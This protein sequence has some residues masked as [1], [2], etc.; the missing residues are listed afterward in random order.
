MNEK[1]RSQ[2]VVEMINNVEKIVRDYELAIKKN[3]FDIKCPYPK[4]IKAYENIRQTLINFGW[5]EQAMIFNE[6]VK[7]YQEKLE[8]DKKLRIIEAQKVQKQ[9]EIEDFYKKKEIDTIRAVLLSLNREE[10]ILDFEEKKEEKLKES[11][12]IFNM[13]NN[14]ERMGKEYEKEIKKGRILQLDCPYEKIIEIYKNAEKKFNNIGWKKEAN[15]I[16]DSIKYYNDK[17]EKDKKLR[18]IEEEK[19]N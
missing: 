4:I 11:E 8:K 18:V 2:V 7:F 10:K 6:Q 14:A 13:I 16:F 5:N 15:K 1:F 9:K 19:K 17:I 3:K 12:E